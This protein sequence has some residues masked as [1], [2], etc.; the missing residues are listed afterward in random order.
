M[1]LKLSRAYKSQRLIGLLVSPGF[2]E[3]QGFEAPGD[4]GRATA[5]RGLGGSVMSHPPSIHS[6]SQI[7]TS[8]GRW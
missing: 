6:Y 2:R 1:L 3:P 8:L 7:I 4:G 5:V